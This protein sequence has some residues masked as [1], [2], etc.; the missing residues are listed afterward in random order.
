MQI[1]CYPHL[2]DLVELPGTDRLCTGH[3]PTLQPA[4]LPV[5]A[6]VSAY[7]YATKSA[8]AAVKICITFYESEN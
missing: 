4:S 5:A 6:E 1:P 8:Y 7:E 3:A 2:V